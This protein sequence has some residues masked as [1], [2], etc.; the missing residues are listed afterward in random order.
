MPTSEAIVTASAA[1]AQNGWTL[2]IVWHVFFGVLVVA[3]LTRTISLRTLGWLLVPSFTSVSA[4]AWAAGNP[5]NGG[6]FALLSLTLAALAARLPIERI[7]VAPSPA[8]VAGL[9]LFSFGWFYPHFLGTTNWPQYAV[10][11][12]LGLL[13]CPTLSAVSGVVLMFGLYRSRWWGG[14]IAG[15]SAVYGIL[16][17]FWLGVAIDVVLVGGAFLLWACSTNPES[18][19][20]VDPLCDA[21]KAGSGNASRA[22]RERFLRLRKCETERDVA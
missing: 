16:G 2:A 22:E 10:A 15:A 5:V 8:F 4:V 1:I 19:R 13:P 7:R 18:S 12:P 6:L 14:T 9:V 21:T 11:A 17:V 20:S 3:A